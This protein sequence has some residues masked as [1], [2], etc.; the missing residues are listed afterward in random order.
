[1]KAIEQDSG[2]LQAVKKVKTKQNRAEDSNEKES[3]YSRSSTVSTSGGTESKSF[4]CH[5]VTKEPGV[6][7]KK[8]QHRCGQ[9]KHLQS[10]SVTAAEK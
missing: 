4:L 1:M 8:R 7:Y 9:I 6:Q 5:A 2:T 10:L 3:H